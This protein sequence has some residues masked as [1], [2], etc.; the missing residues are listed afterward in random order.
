MIKQPRRSLRWQM[1]RRG[2]VPGDTTAQKMSRS[3]H[4]GRDRGWGQSALMGQALQKWH[5]AAGGALRIAAIDAVGSQFVG[6]RLLGEVLRGRVSSM[7]WFRRA[8]PARA[9]TAISSAA[10]GPQPGTCPY[11]P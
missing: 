9:L 10:A 4:S 2:R 11:T 8:A 1:P 6:G 7:E 5:M 3:C